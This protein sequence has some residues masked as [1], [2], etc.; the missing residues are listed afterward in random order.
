VTTQEENPRKRNIQES[1]ESRSK[2]KRNDTIISSVM[3]LSNKRPSAASATEQQREAWPCLIYRLQ[4]QRGW[5]VFSPTADENGNN[6]GGSASGGKKAAASKKSS[7]PTQ[8]REEELT[9]A[10]RKGSVEVRKMRLRVKLFEQNQ[11]R[12]SNNS[13]TGNAK[14]NH[15]DEEQ[16]EE[17]ENNP[18]FVGS[19]G[20]NN[21][22]LVVRR[23][24]S[25]LVTTRRGMGALVFRFK[26]VQQCLEF[27]DRLIYLNQDYFMPSSSS[28]TNR[29]DG[30]FDQ[31][32]GCLN[33]MDQRELYVD[34]MRSN[35]R[36]KADMIGD[37]I[38]LWNSSSSL[39]PN[40]GSAHE[41]YKND[42]VTRV[43]RDEYN[44]AVARQ[45]RRKDELLSYVVK[46]A[47]DEDFQ[48]FV[49]ELERGLEAVNGTAGVFDSLQSSAAGL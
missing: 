18:D 24:D 23:K 44:D 42:E 25:L 5:E 20:W 30:M 15:N 2:S 19:D 10:P 12:D 26:S 36:R 6:N 11:P 13:N 47:H 3:S 27:C 40:A 38:N 17:H 29:N 35:K 32:T 45:Y 8:S 22:A 34:G 21:N 48:G 46:L 1:R 28:N 16:T 39:F 37:Q 4:S 41:Q 7:Q 43:E 33:G 49:D 31:H 9:V 14:Q